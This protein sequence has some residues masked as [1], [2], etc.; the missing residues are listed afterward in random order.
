MSLKRAA[1]LSE[2]RAE[3][4]IFKSNAPGQKV[5]YYEPY[6]GCPTCLVD[7]PDRMVQSILAG[8]KNQK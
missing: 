3:F 5:N 7:S 4:C 6:V 2:M 1:K 8:G